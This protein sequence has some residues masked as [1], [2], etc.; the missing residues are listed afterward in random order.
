[1]SDSFRRRISKLRFRNKVGN[2]QE[3][4][5]DVEL[6]NTQLHDANDIEE[7]K[8]NEH[9]VMNSVKNIKTM[10]KVS[11]NKSFQYNVTEIEEHLSLQ[12]VDLFIR[13]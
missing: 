1:M 10:R 6:V 4:K 3:R 12:E 7:L 11:I 8:F 2:F 13:K 9:A 5:L